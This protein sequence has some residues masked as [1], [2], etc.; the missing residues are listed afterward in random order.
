MVLVIYEV[1]GDYGVTSYLGIHTI[2]TAI[3]Q[4][5]FRMYDVDS[6]MRLAAWLMVIIVGIFILERL[7]RQG[8]RYH[9]SN[10]SR[11]LVP[12]KLKGP[13]G[14]AAFMYCGII[15][16]VGFLI[17][18]VQLIAWAIMTFDK[19]WDSTFFTLSIK[20][21]MLPSYLPYLFFFWRL[22]SPILA[23]L[24]LLFRSSYRKV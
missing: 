21:F 17:P 4:T 13:A 22:W 8:R 11:P 9:L 2:S 12:V 15:F 24:I 6:A 19:V 10:K 7:L 5:W 16:L 23:V 3:F 14:I 1:L 18:L 20:R